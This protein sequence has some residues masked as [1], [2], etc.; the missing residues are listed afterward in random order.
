MPLRPNDFELV[1]INL[2]GRTAKEI[3]CQLICY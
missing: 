1:P 3:T 2:P